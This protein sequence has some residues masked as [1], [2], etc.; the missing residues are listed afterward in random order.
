MLVDEWVFSGDQWIAAAYKNLGFATLVGETTGGMLGGFMHEGE[1]G[2]TYNMMLP[3]SGFIVRFDNTLML[4][5]TGRPVEYGTEP[6]FF[7]RPG[8]DALGTV[9]EMIHEGVKYDGTWE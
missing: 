6:H 1:G 9:L 7:N 5:S 4:D 8:L 2:G 3:N